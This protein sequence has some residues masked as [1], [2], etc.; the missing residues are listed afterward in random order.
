[1]EPVVPQ[2]VEP[3]SASL[4]FQ[5]AGTENETVVTLPNGEERV[6][7]SV[8]QSSPGIPMAMYEMLAK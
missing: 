3:T 8:L 1:M 6:Q 7:L 2:H 5:A 4:T